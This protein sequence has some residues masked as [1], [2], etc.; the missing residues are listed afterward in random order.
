MAHGI[1]AAYYL[2]RGSVDLALEH[3][4]L[5]RQAVSVA[6]PQ[7]PL[8]PML[9]ELPL[10]EAG[11]HLLAGDLPAAAAALQR[12]TAPL[13]APIVDE[14]R[15]TRRC[16]PGWRSCR[17]TWSQPER[18]WTGSAELPRNTAPWRTGWD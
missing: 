14:F 12:G 17:A 11:A 2:N 7:G 18:R 10:Q 15:L 5:A 4:R 3:N 13:S 9:A 6:A 8:F 16:R 1:W